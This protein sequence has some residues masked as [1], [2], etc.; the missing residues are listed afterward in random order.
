MSNERFDQDLRSVLLED[1]P[2]DVPDDLRHRVAAVP[3]THPVVVRPSQAPWRRPV[4]VWAA[5]LTAAAVVLAVGVLQFRPDPQPG[6]GSDPSPNPPP[7]STPSPVASSDGEVGGCLAV[8]LNARILAWQGAAGGRIADVRITNTTA[9]ACLIQGTPGLEL[10]DAGGR[11][12]IDSA[13]AGSRGEP[14]VAASD[15][16]YEL[17]PDGH[18][19]TE[20]LASNYC[21]PTAEMPID[22]AI[23]LPAGGG[24]IVAEPE[25]GVSS[26]DAIPPCLGAASDA[27][28][29]MNGWRP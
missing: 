7:S 20:V 13:A 8:D 28:I 3:D 23:R 21:G 12:L 14:H 29:A 4:L 11:V 18:L 25:A 19:G 6:I 2:P 9:R 24:R 16:V 10:V 15:P 27:Q 26:A 1:A 17:G 5:A 22:I